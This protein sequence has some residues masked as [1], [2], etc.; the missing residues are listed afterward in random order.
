MALGT[1]T[2]IASTTQPDNVRMT[3]FSV[4]LSTGANHVEAGS[5]LALGSTQT[6]FTA[7]SYFHEEVYAVSPS[8]L[9]TDAG[10]DVGYRFE[11]VLAASGAPATGVLRVFLTGAAADSAFSSVPAN[12]D[13]SG[14]VARMVAWGR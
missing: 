2:L 5:A 8:G 1:V 13:L 11:Y 4:Q 6:A 10:G 14:Q 3:I 12:T 9:S 7:Q